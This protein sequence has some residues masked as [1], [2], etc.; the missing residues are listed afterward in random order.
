MHHL[1]LSQA[2]SAGSVLTLMQESPFASGL[3]IAAL[4]TLFPHRIYA[5]QHLRNEVVLPAEEKR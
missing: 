5:P 4:Y 3:F 2:L 1:N